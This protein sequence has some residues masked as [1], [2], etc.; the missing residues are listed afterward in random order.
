M[1]Y[2]ILTAVMFMF[3]VLFML[4]P[5]HFRL[6]YERK[7]TEDCFVID[8][9]ALGKLIRYRLTIPAAEL[10]KLRKVPWLESRF[11]SR[12]GEIVTHTSSE[13]VKS[14]LWLVFSLTHYNEVQEKI[15]KIINLV[16]DYADFMRW[17]TSKVRFERFYW[18][19]RIGLADAADTA[20]A[21]GFF[22]SVKG[23]ITAALWHKHYHTAFR[24]LLKVTPVYNREVFHSDFECIFSVRLG[25]IIGAVIRLLR[26]KI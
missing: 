2:T 15:S 23:Y 9:T 10:V 14:R 16:H 22:W 8:T 24:P 21:V 7:E 13:Q 4:L 17:V 19:T 3:V 18:V 12:G 26:Y 6:Y 1:Q 25:H 5:F 11:K 20:I